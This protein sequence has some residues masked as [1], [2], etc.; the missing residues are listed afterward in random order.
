MSADS[1]ASADRTPR[2][3]TRRSTLVAG[4]M[5]APAWFL[6]SAAGSPGRAAAA[7]ASDYATVRDQ[8]RGTLIGAYDTSDQVIA[9]YAQASADTA[10]GLW[11]TLNTANSRT[12][13]WQDL[14]SSTVSAVQRD[15]VG[16]LRQLALAYA[17]PGSSL[18]GSTA[19]LADLRSALDWFLA[20]KYG[21]GAS[22]DNWWDFQIGIPLALNDIC[23]ALYDKLTAAE[24]ATAMAAIARYLPDPS[25]VGGGTATGANLNWTCAITTVRGALSEDGAVIDNAM[26]AIAKLFPYST[27]GDGFYPDGGFIQHGVFAYNGSYGVSLLQYLT[28]LLVAVQGTPWAATADQVERVHT[29][30][31]T[32][33]RPWIY[34]GAF[35]DMVRGRALSRFYEN[36]HRIGRLTTA[37]L[38][39]L[40]RVF[41]A[42]QALT[43]RS[44][45]KGWIAADTYQ[46]FFT[47]DS[48]P[49]EQVRI[50][51][52][53]LGR[54]V[55]ADGAIPTA[56]ESTASVVATSMA[57]V[58]HRRPAF[59]FA[60]AMDGTHIKPYE[61]AN[62]ENLQGW[63]TGEG[64]TYL[65]L[66]TQPGHWVNEYWPT[67]NKYR[68]PG[69]TLD[70]KTLALGTNR[71]SANTWTGGALLDG[72]VA[73]GMGLAFNVQ[74]LTGRK[75]WFCIEDVVICLGAGISSTDGHTVE[76]VIENRNIG[77]NGRA[78]IHAD[79]SVVLATPS[80]TPTVLQ[81][82]WVYVD[83]LGG[84][85]FPVGGHVT[86]VREDRTG[87]WTDMDHRGV[88]DDT[89]SYTRRFITMWVDHGVS[90][91]AG[92]YRYYQLPAATSAQTEAFAAANDVTVAA[93]TAQVQAVRRADSGVAM[94]NVWQAGAPKAAGIQVD[95]TAS[96]VTA[97]KDGRLSVAV[98]DPT[99]QL[100]GTVTVTVDGAASAVTSTDPGVTVLA[101]SPNVKLAVAVGGAA[102]RTFVARFTV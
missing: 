70:T 62:K 29:W 60:I 66:P 53:A 30:T 24:I 25:R 15:V 4:A 3:I 23:V 87:K 13:L 8:W 96:V 61:S 6:G 41:P 49:L 91:T 97:R 9:R 47:Y 94:A 90:P 39:Q 73:A 26:T 38:L 5:L 16:R 7:T 69:V 92:S 59:A 84:Y 86:M 32:N 72:N 88:Y 44:Q 18:S 77:P 101:T 37:T 20:H 89:A 28:Y 54:A 27:S 98:S 80:S 17:S 48:V 40:A 55:V 56:A 10:H 93:N 63:Y 65:Y 1:A 22:Y 85:V 64:A 100:T 74:T 46:D 95:R 21:V 35:M 33:Y 71:G 81:P 51:S 19:L 68:L 11:S 82:R 102:G 42:A 31:Q 78:D 67:A 57:R 76:S 45:A 14:D 36:D 58:V 83:N 79:G 12:Y 75:S 99:R 34:R 50:S 52:I 2:G 43:L